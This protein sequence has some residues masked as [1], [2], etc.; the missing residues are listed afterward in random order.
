MNDF[1]IVTDSSCDLPYSYIQEHNLTCLPLH[2]TF[3]G[4]EYEDDLG[5]DNL[6]KK[7]YEA[8]R[9]GAMT[10]TAQV[11]TDSFLSFFSSYLEKGIDLL[12]LGFSSA[13]SG[14]FASA[15][16]AQGMLSKKFPESKLI[17]VDTLCASMG[18]GMLVH[19]CLKKKEEGQGIDEIA[20]WAEENK[21]KVNHCF[22]VDDLT[23]LKRGGRVSGAAAFIAS[24]LDIKP[25]MYVDDNGRLVPLS[26]TRGRKKSI[27]ALVDKV[28]QHA[29]DPAN[30]TLMITHGDCMED[31]QLAL[32]LIEQ[33]IRFK[34][35]YI[36]EVG[37]TIGS[38][39]GPGTLAIF[40]MS[41][42]RY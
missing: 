36:R 3:D 27:R 22:T 26:K 40:F 28:I 5:K 31:V 29:V 17:V 15:H 18:Q 25:V 12:Y 13:L 9:R 2:F 7:L 39:S 30:N 33:E 1:I 11:N 38:H 32:K 16:A 21:L 14:T 23:Y 37:P 35:V 6:A 24:M 8:M 34:E 41:D 4:Q 10:S 19:H 42:K 20:Q